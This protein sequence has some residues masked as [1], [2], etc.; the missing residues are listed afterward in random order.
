MPEGEA[1]PEAVEAADPVPA[2][3]EFELVGEAD[4]SVPFVLELEALAELE[5]LAEV[6]AGETVTVVVT[7]RVVPVVMAVAVVVV[8][9]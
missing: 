5:S 9:R 2:D 6:E 1:E 4:D 8:R 7:T 3:P